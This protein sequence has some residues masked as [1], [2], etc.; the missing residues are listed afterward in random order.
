MNEVVT[1]VIDGIIFI[2]PAFIANAA[3][4]FLGRGTKYNAPIDGGKLWKDNRRILGNGKTIRGFIG[5]TMSGMVICAVIFLLANQFSY[6]LSFMSNFEKSF[7]YSS[8]IPLNSGSWTSTIVLGLLVGF[9]LGSG[10]LV[11]DLAGSFLKRRRGL[12]RGES[13]PLMDQLG[14]LFTALLFVY[15][16]MPWPLYWLII[17][18]PMTL[19]LHIG[20]NLLSYFVGMQEVP[21]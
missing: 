4:V 1:L 14:F 5:G 16:I 12:K 3:P 2:F 17:L 15:P 19:I 7:F 8:L 10:S 6:S 13:F 11:G 20:L 21:F 9:L 18:I